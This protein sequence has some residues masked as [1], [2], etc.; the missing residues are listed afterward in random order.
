MFREPLHR[1]PGGMGRR[2]ILLHPL[3]LEGVGA[4]PLQRPPELAQ[5]GD[6]PLLIDRHRVTVPVLKEKRTNDALTA[7]RAPYG[8]FWRV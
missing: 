1:H 3:L 8:Y 4:L 6:V 7:Q 2:T 5:D